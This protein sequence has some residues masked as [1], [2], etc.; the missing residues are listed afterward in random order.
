MSAKRLDASRS[1]KLPAL[2]PIELLVSGL[3]A[4]L[5]VHVFRADSSR[6][7]PLLYI[8]TAALIGLPFVLLSRFSTSLDS[9]KSSIGGKSSAWYTVQLGAIGFGLLPLLLQL[10]LRP[11]G[12]G[13]A[14]EV[15]AVN[16]VQCAAWFLVV[17]SRD[18]D[19][20]KAAFAMSSAVVLFACFMSD[21]R[22][23]LA[24][25]IL[26]A[27]MA[28]WWLMGN[29]W[30]RVNVKSIDGT[31]QALPIH[32]LSYIGVG[33][34]IAVCG[35]IAFSLGPSEQLMAVNGFMPVSG[36]ENWHETYSRSGLGDGDMLTAGQNA[37]TTGAV[38]SDQFIEDDKPSMYDIMTE[39]YGGPMKIKKRQNRAVALD[40]IGKHVDDVKQSE[41]SGKSFRTARR[42][43]KDK[44]KTLDE[45]ITDALFFVEGSVPARF[46]TAVYHEFDGLDWSRV[47]TRVKRKLDPTIELQE[48]GGKPWYVLRNLDREFLNT[49]RSHKI[50]IMRF[51]SATI[52]APSFMK[53]WHIFQ[54]NLADMFYW[55]DYGLVRIT[56]ECIP[57]QTVIDVVSQVPNY[58]TLRHSRN[59]H[60]FNDPSD[61]FDNT[62]RSL[63]WRNSPGTD[64]AQNTPQPPENESPFLQV[65]EA[66]STIRLKQLALQVTEGIE[67]GW[68]QV[69]AVV[70][71]LKHN[72]TLDS[73]LVVPE[74]CESPVGHFLDE[75]RGPSYLFSTTGVL[76]LRSLGYETRLTS[77][78]VVQRKD[79]ISK[80]G[81]SVVTAENTHTWPEVRLE[82]WHWIP[83]EPTPTYPVPYGSDTL[84]QRG[85][86]CLVIVVRWMWTH[87]ILMGLSLGLSILI[88]WNYRTLASIVFWLKWRL[89]CFLFPRRRLALT[90]QFIDQR[91]WAA[92]LPRPHCSP[93]GAWYSKVD[94]A[95]A[96]EFVNLWN[97]QNFC[98]SCEIAQESINRTSR[99]ITSQLTFQRIK[100]FAKQQ[101]NKA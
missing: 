82:G 18:P 14:F 76:M 38:D 17:C 11:F 21:Q 44:Q 22:G 50:K 6:F 62:L 55:D 83:V 61:W 68:N 98:S 35:W 45:R 81:Q 74:D 77:G 66:P 69:E 73:K 58:H 94:S 89:S 32:G 46:A 20:Q 54:V 93:I 99:E 57:T 92:G 72:F 5:V 3:V 91:F 97:F 67:P 9:R 36:G 88:T 37:T 65:P 70:N 39:K 100:K 52:P 1:Q 96:K 15:V 29:Y 47:E 43:A 25:G 53:S 4:V 80:S 48:K 24:L 95:S 86:D 28:M 60:L 71:H 85:W 34:A 40:T 87:P 33:V 64:S 10:L 41:L 79:Y 42:P 31:S 101:D 75:A 19:R 84:L 59:L 13:E 26:Y 16:M 63:G 51:D 12:L 56:G 7:M 90:R 2:P 49:Y 27:G 23:V 30:N 8:E 78:F